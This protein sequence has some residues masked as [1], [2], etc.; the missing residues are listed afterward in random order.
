M[1]IFLAIA[2]FGALFFAGYVE[3]AISGAILILSIWV[4]D[5]A[6]LNAPQKYRNA[7]FCILAAVV[8]LGIMG[9]LVP[10]GSAAITVVLAYISIRHA[11][12]VARMRTAIRKFSTDSMNFTSTMREE[13][14]KDDMT[15]SEDV[16][17]RKH[18]NWYT[19]TRKLPVKSYVFSSDDWL[20]S[21][22]HEYMV[23]NNTIQRGTDN[24]KTI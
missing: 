14:P 13:K 3:L 2:V 8:V 22:I 11:N 18:T 15:L 23:N 1:L 16:D 20:R 21:K 9:V 17:I 7:G 24:E 4:I 10:V 6:T 12:N 19:Y 5:K